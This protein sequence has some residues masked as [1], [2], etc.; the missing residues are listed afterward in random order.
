MSVL[1][2][3]ACEYAL[4]ALI[5][6]AYHPEKNIWTVK[7]LAEPTD[8][9]APF[10]AKTLQTLVKYGILN[11]AKGRR[12]GFSFNQPIN[13]IYVMDIVD[14]IDGPALVEECALGFAH[15]NDEN[16]CPFHTQWDNI[17]DAII[18]ALRTQSL[19]QLVEQ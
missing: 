15:C 9:P 17:R 16:S 10:L 18:H 13:K 14:I 1:F 3:R 11:S 5:E 4:R 2:S 12:G 19:E 6:M 7:E 8:T